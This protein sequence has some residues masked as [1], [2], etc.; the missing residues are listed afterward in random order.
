MP[1]DEQIGEAAG[2]PQTLR[3]LRQSAIAH[4]GK[5]EHTL[6]DQKRM[7]DFGAHLGFRAILAALHFIHDA[8]M[9]IALVGEIPGVRRV[10]TDLR[11]IRTR[12]PSG[13]S[14]RIGDFEG[15]HPSETVG[16][17]SPGIY[18]W[19]MRTP[20]D[21]R[22]L[23]FR[24]SPRTTGVPVTLWLRPRHHADHAARVWVDAQT[25][26]SVEDDPP[27]LLA[28]ELSATDLDAVRR[29]I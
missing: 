2:H 9:A 24:L 16:A 26:V 3:V 7:L 11:R 8:A 4:L 21:D 6:D 19:L 14:V 28:G 25:A 18:G 29:Y 1:D 15:H 27:Q 13:T 17:P 20:D 5:T 10:I 12:G 22:F 23:M